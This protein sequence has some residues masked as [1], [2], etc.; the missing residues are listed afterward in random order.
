VTCQ[1]S[2]GTLVQRQTTPRPNLKSHQLQKAARQKRNTNPAI[3]RR[4]LTT[5]P[6]P[7]P[8]PARVILRSQLRPAPTSYRQRRRNHHTFRASLASSARPAAHPHRRHERRGEDPGHRAQDRARKGPDQCRQ[9]HAPA[10]AQRGCPLQARH[11]DARGPPEPRVFREP[12]PG[13]ADAQDEPWRR[14]SLPERPGQPPRRRRRREGPPAAPQGRRPGRLRR[15]GLRPLR[16]G[17]SA[18]ALGRPLPRGA[19][20][21]GGAQD[22]AQLFQA[23]YVV[24]S[25][26]PG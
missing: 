18:D 26:A 24:G 17:R 21:L 25:D 23:R 19:A 14:Q 1:D 5:F 11:A 3:I 10:D 13:A 9:P 2:L 4:S 15:V 20:R 12:P 22:A 6:P 7:T 16:P 8:P